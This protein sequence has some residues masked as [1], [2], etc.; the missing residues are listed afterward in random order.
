MKKDVFKR[1]EM[2]RVPKGHYQSRKKHAICP[3][4]EILLIPLRLN[5]KLIDMAHPLNTNK[6][7]MVGNG[8]LAF[9]VIFIVVIFVYMGMK[10]QRDKQKSHYYTEL[11]TISL[12]K[13]F[14]KDSVSVLINDSLIDSRLINQEPFNLEVKRFADQS[15]L[16]IVDHQTEVTSSF[17]LSESGGRYRFVKETD[18][19]KQLGQE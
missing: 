9:A 3:A 7:F 5:F 4:N 12:T 19:I 2:R 17:N 16:M 11:Y 15:I 6:Q 14:L 10:M 13:G 18:G 8:I 1:L